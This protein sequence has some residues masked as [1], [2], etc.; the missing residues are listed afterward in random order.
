MSILNRKLKIM[1]LIGSLVVLGF[2]IYQIATIGDVH[3]SMVS[4]V[5]S[6]DVS[7]NT[8]VPVT[9]GISLNVGVAT[10]GDA[11]FQTKARSNTDIYNVLVLIAIELM[12]W[13][14]WNVVRTVYRILC[15]FKKF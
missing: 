15:D 10:A 7:K 1:I 2:G 4:H 13:I 5:Y 8:V 6:Y 9:D 14:M 11:G 3:A 12:F